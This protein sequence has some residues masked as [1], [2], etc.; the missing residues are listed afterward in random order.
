MAKITPKGTNLTPAR[1][2]Q[3]QLPAFM[4][5]E[6]DFGIG[7]MVEYIVPARLKIVQKQSGPPFDELY[8][9]GTVIMVPQMSVISEV[10]DG[11]QG[12]PFFFVPVFFFAEWCQ[13]NPLETKG[14]LPS[15]RSRTMNP[16]DPLVAKCRDSRLWHE[17]CPEMPDKMIRNVEHLNFLVVLINHAFS[18]LPILISF[19]RASHR[20]GSN[21]A[22]LIKMRRAPIYGCQFMAQTGYRTNNKGQWYGLDA[23]NP[24]EDSGVSPFVESEEQFNQFKE[25]HNQLKEAH[26]KSQ[27]RPDYDDT[28]EDETPAESKEF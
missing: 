8:D 9:P 19:S 4:Q 18:G 13:W 20:S 1:A 16:N 14:T 28:P 6:T 27:I 15:I 11:R 23:L 10:G 2:L 22:A 7:T 24:T 17:Q 12:K 21:L 5:N 26:A 3:E 25:L